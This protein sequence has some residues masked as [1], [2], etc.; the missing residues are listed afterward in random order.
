MKLNQEIF[1]IKLY[2]MEQQYGKL[3]SRLHI[4]GGEDQR[5]IRQELKK[6]MDEYKEMAVLLQKNVEGSRSQAV[7]ELAQ[8]QLDFTNKMR[9]LLQ[10]Q[11]ARYLHSEQSSPVEDEA[12]AMTLYAEY[13]IDIATQSMQYALITALAAMDLQMSTE[14][15]GEAKHAGSQKA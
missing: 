14:K 11:L 2:E 6:A 10:G 5:K 13:A 12:E 9:Q 8:A 7:T 3:Q 1:A 15:K 4:C